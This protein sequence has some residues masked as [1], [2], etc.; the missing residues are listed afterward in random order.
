MATNWQKYYDMRERLNHNRIIINKTE[1][2]YVV[3]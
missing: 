3:G 1:C 2:T